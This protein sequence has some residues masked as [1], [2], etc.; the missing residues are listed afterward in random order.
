[1]TADENAL[2]VP[3]ELPVPDELVMPDEWLALVH[4]R[5]GEPLYGPPVRV[6]PDAVRRVRGMTE[7]HRSLI[8]G[9]ASHRDAHPEMTEA[10]RA[11]LRGEPDPLGAAA[12]ATVLVEKLGLRDEDTR[13]AFLDAWIGEHGLP[14]AA[15]AFAHLSGISLGFAPPPPGMG[16]SNH[17]VM[18]AVGA[19]DDSGE[20]VAPES[21]HGGIR[22]AGGWE[23]GCEWSAE[24]S[25]VLRLRTLLATASDEDYRESVRRLAVHR[26]HAAQLLDHA[27]ERLDHAARRQAISYLVP[28]EPEWLDECVA[29]LSHLTRAG[30]TQLLCSVSTAHHA[31]TLRSAGLYWYDPRPDVVATMVHALGPAAA[32]FLGRALGT[33]RPGDGSEGRRAVLEGLAMLPSDEA[34]QMLA[35]RIGE[36]DINAAVRSAMDRFPARAL[37]VL[38]RMAAAETT[39]AML[40]T[41]LLRRWLRAAPG[42]ADDLPAETRRTIEPHL[43]R[44]AVP[45]AEELPPLLVQP[46]WKH[47][48][49]AKAKEAVPEPPPM[50]EPSMHWE[51]GEREVWERADPRNP[52]VWTKE[53]EID[54]EVIWVGWAPKVMWRARE[55]MP[56]IVVRFGLDALPL[57]SR[58]AAHSPANHGE[59][60]LPYFGPEVARTMARW[61]ARLKSGRTTARRWFRRH[62][63]AAVPLL[64]PDAFGKAGPERR[65][66]EGALRLL[67][68]QHGDEAI[69]EAAGEAGPAVTALLALDPLEV[70]PARIPK[71]TW[72]DPS[73]LPQILLR[74]RQ[75]AL[76]AAATGHV[77]TMLAMSKPGE[78]YAGLDT[79]RELCDPVSLA[80][81]SWAVFLHWQASG[82]PTK[83]NWALTQLGLV[84]DDTTVRRL[85]PLIRLWPGESATARAVNALEVLAEIGSD[86]A[87][88]H[89]YMLARKGKY[90]G[91]KAK[92]L[93]KVQEIA[94]ARGLTQDQLA[95]RAVPDFGLDAEG[96]MTFDYGPRR[97]E[98]G[99]D[100]QLKPYVFEKHSVVEG[101]GKRRQSLPKP[102]PS[103][104]PDLAPAAYTLFAGLKKDVR[105]IA[106]GEIKRLESAMVRGRRW[107]TTEFR[108]AFLG[109]PLL[110]HIVRRLV[111]LAETDEGITP[112][113]VAE[114]RTFADVGD[115]A[116]VPPASSRIGI[117]H[118]VLLGEALPAWAE[119][120][121]DYEILQPFAQLGR[122]VHTLTDEERTA[123]QLERLIDRV[124]PYGKVKGLSQGHWQA[125]DGYGPG[126]WIARRDP[127]GRHLVV[128]ISPGLGT[129][130]YGEGDEQT[131]TAIWAGTA[132]GP[133]PESTVP[134]GEIDPVTLSEAL[135][136]LTRISTP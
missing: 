12:V 95:D 72:V 48:T 96:G 20:P 30:H 9:M 118:P 71:L 27:A 42:L 29:D 7:V 49:K 56:P 33:Q 114:D 75:R 124:A 69:V 25:F 126:P 102:G 11:W 100:E 66:A 28:T 34:I 40:V 88:T 86:V 46:P 76:P 65:D 67:A 101:S 57:V 5:R 44:A 15:E 128:N 35:E 97:F 98:V 82:S 17:V 89:L 41:G 58:V 36:D 103:D 53:P 135:Y 68:T 43:P 77:L 74:N 59:M 2:A 6:D 14:F 93:A 127:A 111:W 63:A 45:D 62:G 132:P 23:R 136:D 37:R 92:A 110:W 105:T 87:L 80:E 13:A 26:D 1:M 109:H 8:E 83:D 79:V 116:F 125:N 134:L 73:E 119:V 112:F 16:G 120:F 107:T 104:D 122:P 52:P 39:S 60:L 85:S 106:D 19:V 70:L 47:R 130:M 90:K 24:G 113:R 55:W 51:P 4:P 10:V 3:D 32:R 54:W 121:A 22:R 81:F 91:L 21:H 84:G 18:F 123:T 115:E 78:A 50:P 131:Y 117:A 94:E 129:Y 99:F 38:G 31:D 61:F 108:D 64:L 133:K